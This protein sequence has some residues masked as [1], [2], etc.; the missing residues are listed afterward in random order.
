[1][2][3]LATTA[4]LDRA[5]ALA[6]DE[7]P[8]DKA[9]LSAVLAAARAG[10]ESAGADKGFARLLAGALAV[11]RRYFSADLHLCAIVNAK[12]GG[13]SEDCAFCAQSGRHKT[14]SPRHAFLEPGEI[15]RAA[16]RARAH[17]ASR[18]GI[19]A[20]GLTPARDDFERLLA[21]VRLVR[22]A[23][24]AAD[25]SVG[26]LGPEKLARLIDAGLSGVHHNLETARSF[27]PQ[28]C[29]THA[30][31]DDV[32]A[33]RLALAAGLF[34]CSGGIF[35]LGESWE[36]RAEL[37]QTLL[38]LGVGNVPVNFLVPIPGTR[39]EHRPVLSR[40]EALGI[41]ALL[42]LMLPRANLRVCGGRATVFG[43]A[44][45]DGQHALFGSAMSGLMIG[46]YLTLKGSPAEEDLDL[47]REM[48]LTTTPPAQARKGPR[49]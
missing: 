43:E 19:V 8:L 36:E 42:R 46:D 14:A 37:G 6:L 26:L 2:S 23:G 21:A 30:Y 49:P 35:G 1:M 41:L 34:V 9:A 11:R 24:L 44:A 27:F 38:E 47:A 4:E 15:G 28:I 40:P 33:V 31:E 29:T 18:F 25:V 22:E 20:S 45:G 32:E 48:G 39:L 3:G 5:I 13:C 12:S 17:G 7:R 16:A 10:T